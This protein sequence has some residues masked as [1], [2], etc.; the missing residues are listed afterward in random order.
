MDGPFHMRKEKMTIFE[1]NYS[2]ILSAPPKCIRTEVSKIIRTYISVS[3]DPPFDTEGGPQSKWLPKDSYPGNNEFNNL[4]TIIQ[5]TEF[6]ED[7][8]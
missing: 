1:I 3:A 5:T 6:N 8:M 4:L 2:W 7:Q